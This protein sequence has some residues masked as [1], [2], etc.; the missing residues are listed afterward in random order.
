MQIKKKYKYLFLRLASY[1]IIWQIYLLFM[2]TYA[3]LGTDWLSWHAQRIYNFSEYLRLNGFF[4]SYGFSIWSQCEGCSL[5]LENWKNKIYLSFNIFS[6]FPYVIINNLFGANNLYLYGHI[7]DKFIILLAGILLSELFI[8]LSAKKELNISIYLKSVI[9]FIFFTINPWTYKMIL[10]FWYNIFFVSFFLLG[11]LTLVNKKY[12][13]G[14][15]FFLISGFFDYQS[16][17]GLALFYILILSFFYFKNEFLL[18]KNYIPSF[19]S[20]TIIEFK[21]IIAFLVPV[22]FFFIFKLIAVN[23]LGVVDGTSLLYRIGIS[24]NDF[25]NGGIF[26]AIQFLGGNR[27]TQCLTDLNIDINSMDLNTKIYI[28]NCMLSTLSMFFVSLISIFGLYFLHKNEKKYFNLVILPIFFLLL[29]YTFLLQQSS[30][31]HLMG[32]SYF[33]S[34]LFSIGITS[35]IFNIL[36]K[37][38]F[39]LLSILIISPLTIGIFL[40]CIR[41]NMLTG[42]N[43]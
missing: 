18:L 24:G 27:I 10:G 38:K 40:L 8:I 23:Q 28:F 7:L 33:F 12:F 35:L 20:S 25:N 17:A 43:G 19:S 16:S 30:S 22:V 31:V 34:I 21:I 1:I 32:Y 42:V 13:L 26:G 29:L 2:S 41:V 39:S 36:E 14:L 4:S 9:V 37:F 11:I 15:L 6:Y 5:N 3:P